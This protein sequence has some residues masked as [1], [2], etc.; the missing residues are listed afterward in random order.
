M[1]DKLKLGSL[2]GIGEKTELLFAKVGVYTI[3]DL[4]RYY[5]RGYDVYEE[6]IP[7]AEVEEGKVVTVSGAI[8]GRVVLGEAEI[9]RLQHFM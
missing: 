5:P 4:I 3:A 9:C 7:I 2:K 6:P 8:F 1:K